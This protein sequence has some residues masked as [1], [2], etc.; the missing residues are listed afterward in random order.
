MMNKIL[1]V[2]K[3]SKLLLLL[4]IGILLSGCMSIEYN[5]DV[6]EDGSVQIKVIQDITESNEI[7]EE[8][9]QDLF[10]P[11]EDFLTTDDIPNGKCVVEGEN[12]GVITFTE[13]LSD[14]FEAKDGFY[15]LRLPHFAE[16]F[17]EQGEEI[18]DEN[19]KSQETNANAM[20]IKMSIS[21]GLPGEIISTD[22]GTIESNRV[23][24]DPFA[25]LPSGEYFIVS[26][27]PEAVGNPPSWGKE[28]SIEEETKEDTPE[29]VDVTVFGPELPSSGVKVWWNNLCNWFKSLF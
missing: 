12:I 20:G 5:M 16:N 21:V 8:F 22:V 19:I 25:V 11:C 1:T 17:A 6:Q 26:K 3:H 15:R 10:N 13:D 4:S 9:G 7:Q 18:T 28:T 29:D 2:F 14:Q 23:K 24:I 27:G